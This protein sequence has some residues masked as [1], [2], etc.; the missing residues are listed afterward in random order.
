ME[1]KVWCVT[2]LTMNTQPREEKTATVETLHTTVDEL[3]ASMEN[4]AMKVANLFAQVSNQVT[5]DPF[6]KVKKLI[7]DLIW[8]QQWKFLRKTDCDTELST[9]NCPE[10]SLREE[11]YDANF[12]RNE[13]KAT[14]EEDIKDV[15]EAQSN[16]TQAIQILTNF[17]TKVIQN[18]FARLKSE[19]TASESEAVHTFDEFTGKVVNS[20]TGRRECHAGGVREYSS[21]S[22]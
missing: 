21:P 18:D 19:T 22:G 9:T 5:N 11:V 12:I 4:L 7:Q 1:H 20:G 6:M 10:T 8:K 2:E 16:L 14:N 17:Y 13:E 15:Q 3:E